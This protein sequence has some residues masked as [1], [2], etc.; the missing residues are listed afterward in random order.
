[1]YAEHGEDVD[2]TT[3]IAQNMTWWTTDKNI[4]DLFSQFGRIKSLKFLE[5]K[6]N[7]KSKGIALIEYYNKDAGMNAMNKAQGR[8]L[9]GRPL[10]L[11][12]ATPAILKDLQKVNQTAKPQKGRGMGMQKPGK[13]QPIPSY[14]GG[15]MPL[16]M[17]MGM[18]PFR[19]GGRGGPFQ[20]MVPDPRMLGIAPHVNPNFF[21]K[22]E[23]DKDKDRE[24]ERSRSRSRSPRDRRDERDRDDRYR[25]RERDDRHHRDD[26]DRDDRKRH[27]DHRSSRH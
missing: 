24:R 11:S 20:M 26:Y 17:M 9:Q 19:G 25:K 3:V 8:D 16:E 5:D 27:K 6:V 23:W 13:N 12:F 2:M 21:R 18:P 15:G 22:D 14:G 1:M 4:E 7:G 10:A